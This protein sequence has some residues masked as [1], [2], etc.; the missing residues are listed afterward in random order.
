[1][2]DHG[3]AEWLLDS[4]PAIRWQVE[5]D[6]TGAPDEVWRATRSRVAT[7][8]WGAAL[9]SHQDPDGQWGG[10]AYSPGAAYQID[11]R[12]EGQPWIGTTHVLTQLREFG[13][14]PGSE[15]A[16]RTVTLISRNAR[17]E[18][19]GQPYWQGE[20]EPC[21]NGM[22]VANGSYFGV[23]VTPVVNRLVA[24]RL[25]D[26]GWNCE[27]VDGSVVSS[28]DSIIN[29]LEGLLLHR[30][31]AGGAARVLDSRRSGEEYLLSRGLFR[32]LS[33]GE[34]ADSGFLQLGHPFRWYHSVL[35]G[36]DYF[37][38]A[39]EADGSPPDDRLAEAVD[40]LRGKRGADGRWTL[41]RH[42]GGR[43]WITMEPVG[44]TSRW[45]TLHAL[46]IL[47]WWAAGQSA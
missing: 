44:G 8:G 17:W 38:R 11:E 34:P 37:R 1:M 27:A 24:D 36:L 30:F 28:F 47:R 22:V 14:E 29:V 45:I 6:L 18:D 16:R 32:R 5:R 10:G 39:S 15:R 4:D 21:V 12:A 33:T 46:R 7:D 23:D 3:V 25:A 35:R 2:V 20:T 41:E 40:W 42:Y 19:A 31:T 9:L 13:L 26:G 43:A